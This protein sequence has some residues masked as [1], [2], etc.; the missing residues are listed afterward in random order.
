MLQLE[1]RN[2]QVIAARVQLQEEDSEQQAAQIELVKA[3]G[4]L[5][6]LQAERR[7]LM[8][9]WEDTVEALR[10]YVIK[11][12]ANHNCWQINVTWVARRRQAWSSHACSGSKRNC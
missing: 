6:Q 7:G 1:Q 10:R 4:D 5:K 9:Q 8:A 11:L 12:S 3:T 2:T